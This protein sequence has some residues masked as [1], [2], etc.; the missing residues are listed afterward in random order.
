[1]KLCD[2]IIPQVFYRVRRI[3][4]QDPKQDEIHLWIGSSILPQEIIEFLV[5]RNGKPGTT[6]LGT[7]YAQRLESLLE[8]S[9]TF[10]SLDDDHKIWYHPIQF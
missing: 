5:S 3:R 9:Q 10:L 7:D 6:P 4:N 8:N 2:H 1:M